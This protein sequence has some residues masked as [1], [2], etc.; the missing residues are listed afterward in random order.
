MEVDGRNSSIYMEP[1]FYFTFDKLDFMQ[2]A[3]AHRSGE[4]PI[5]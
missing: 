3:H 1:M 2:V 5:T 4:K